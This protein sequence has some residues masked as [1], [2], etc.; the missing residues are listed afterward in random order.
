MLLRAR[1]RATRRGEKR[2]RSRAAGRRSTMASTIDSRM[3][4][5]PELCDIVRL[6]WATDTLPDDG[7]APLAR[8]NRAE[9]ARNAGSVT[10]A[11]LT[12]SCFPS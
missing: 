5:R 6:E 7:A 4:T 2:G 10:H 1:A 8:A 9:R 3:V 12:Y 11:M